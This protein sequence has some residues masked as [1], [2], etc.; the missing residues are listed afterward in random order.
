MIHIFHRKGYES[1]FFW[2]NVSTKKFL[3]IYVKCVKGFLRYKTIT[4][5]NISSLFCRK[6][7]FRSQDIQVFV[8]LT[9]PWFTWSVMTSWWVQETGYI[10]EYIIWA[11]THDVTKLD[12]LIDI[13]KSNNFQESFEQFGGLELSSRSFS[14]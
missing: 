3:Y 9:I 14:I 5:Q 1:I 11:T 10:F 2:C 6:V 4:S 7:M 12:Q 8:F 13:N